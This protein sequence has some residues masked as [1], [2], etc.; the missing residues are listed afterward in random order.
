VGYKRAV[1]TAIFGFLQD[2]LASDWE[3][4][5]ARLETGEAKVLAEGE[6]ASPEARRI[7]EAFTPYFLARDRFRLDPEG[8]SVKHTHWDEESEV[9]QVAQVL[10]DSEELNDWEAQFSVSLPDSRV[11]NRAVVKFDRVAPIGT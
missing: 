7:E 2:V 4:A 3:S 9:W 5:A 10:I 1:R 11:A 8:R 6:P